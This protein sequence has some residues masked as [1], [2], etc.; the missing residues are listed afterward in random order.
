MSTPHT[1]TRVTT[2]VR[3]CAGVALVLLIGGTAACASTD[4]SMPSPVPTATMS[5]STGSPEP[6]MG[7]SE[8]DEGILPGEI[9][10]AWETA[11]GDATLAYRFVSDGKYQFAALLTQPVPEGVFELTHVE[12][13]TATV[14]RD[15]LILHP[16]TAIATRRHP[17]DPGGDYTDRPEPLTAKRYSWHLDRGVLVLADGTGLALTFDRQP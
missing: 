17:S 9:V 1:I 15:V 6:S 4:S 5:S 7:P 13:G 10:G 14:D 2:G 16:A 8:T 12:S 11:G 3:R